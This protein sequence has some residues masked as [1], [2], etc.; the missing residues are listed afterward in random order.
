[1]G[2]QEKGVVRPWDALVAAEALHKRGYDTNLNTG[3]VTK[4][5]PEAK[6]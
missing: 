3:E 1:M 5:E 6:K 2:K 4:R